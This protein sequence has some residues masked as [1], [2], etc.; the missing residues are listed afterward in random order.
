M[1][2][3]L[4]LIVVAQL[5]GTSLWFSA[6]AAAVDLGAAWGVGARELG[7]LA[8]AVQA[9]FIA[10]T[11]LVSL[12]GLADRIPASRIFAASAV[13]G[14]AAN[15]GFALLATALPEGL[16]FRF[17]TGVA[18]AGIY[19]MGMKLVVGWVPE[20]KGRA[21]GWLVGTLTLG[22]AT[23]HLVRALGSEWDWRAV[24]LTSSS[25]ALVAAALIARLGDGPHLPPAAGWRGREAL[26]AFRLAGV[27]AAA[28]AYFGHMWELYAFWTV[29]PLLVGALLGPST[30]ASTV[31]LVSFAVIAAGAAG[32]IGGG[33]LSARLGSARVAAAALLGSGLMCLI[34]PVLD[35][36]PT[37]ALV[38]AL[39]AWGVAVVADSPQ[40]SA[41]TARASPPEVVGGVLA[42]QNSVGFAITVASITLATAEWESLGARVAWLLLPGPLLGLLALRPLL[43]KRGSS[44]RERTV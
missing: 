22:T 3:R 23:P 8:T 37:W 40:F 35:G 7:Y 31:A 15:A 10:G 19:P 4:L 43:G 39:V 20:Q 14:A 28:L 36:L 18:L 26:R 32:C 33:W 25:L 5:F 9:G 27:R 11:A 2:R 44:P 12:S 1:D 42:L 17:A 24:V 38:L 29:T 30:D 41:L 16:A 6:N 13:G 21:L 34:F